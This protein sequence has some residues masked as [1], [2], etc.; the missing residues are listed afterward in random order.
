MD[1]IAAPV[2]SDQRDGD[3][4][5]QERGPYGCHEILAAFKMEDDRVAWLKTMSAQPRKQ[6]TGAVQGLSI[7][8]EHRGSVGVD[9]DKTPVWVVFDRLG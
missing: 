8:P 4:A 5:A 6:A 3:P 2:S 9:V 1:I 7:G